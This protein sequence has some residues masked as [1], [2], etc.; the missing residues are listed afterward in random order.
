MRGRSTCGHELARPRV[1]PAGTPPAGRRGRRAHGGCV[2]VLRPA[3]AGPVGAPARAARPARRDGPAARVGGGPA[4]GPGTAPPS[5]LR[6]PG[7]A[8]VLHPRRRDRRPDAAVHAGGRAHTA[9]HRQR[10]RV[11]RP[12]DGLDV[13]CSRRAQALDGHGRRRRPAADPPLAGWHRRRGAGV[14]PRRRGLL[15]RLHLADP[16]CRRPGHRPERTGGLDPGRRRCRHARRRRLRVRRRDLAAGGHDA[17][18]C[19]AASRAAVQP[20]VPRPAPAHRHGVRHADEPG[21]RDRAARRPARARADP[22][23]GVGRRRHLRGDRRNRCH[24]HGR[25]RP[26]RLSRA[27]PR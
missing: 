16:A 20:G 26:G 3:R 19:G 17:G 5:R 10:A 24:P 14:R 11:P 13:R 7:P 21:A 4:A 23:P 2:D 6:R 12:A 25:P 8:G 9:R 18:A 27:G 22:G 15:G 1:P